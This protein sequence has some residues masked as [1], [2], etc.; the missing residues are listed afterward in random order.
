MTSE[1]DT[2]IARAV[3]AGKPGAPPSFKMA[4]Y[5]FSTFCG[6]RP[7]EPCSLTVAATHELLT[8]VLLYLMYSARI[9]VPERPTLC[10]SSYDLEEV[11]ELEGLDRASIDAIEQIVNPASGIHAALRQQGRHWAAHVLESPRSQLMVAFYILVTVTV[12][13]TPFSALAY[14]ISEYCA[15]SPGGDGGGAAARPWWSY[16]VG[17]LDSLVYFFLPLWT[18]VLLRLLQKRPWLHRIAGRSL[19]VGDTPWVSQSLEAFTSKLFALSYSV[20]GLSVSSG[21][22]LDHLVHR[23]THR[24]VR[25]ALLAVGRPDGRLNGLASAEATCSLSVSQASSI[26][27]WGVTLESFTLGH[28]PIKLGLSASAVFLPRVRKLFLCEHVLENSSGGQGRSSA[29]TWSKWPLGSAPAR[30]LC[31]LRAHLA[32]VGS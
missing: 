9:Y 3:R 17:F 6:L 22:P 1:W 8:Q 31:L 4:S 21:N 15:P 26:Q 25:G 32:V 23:H 14:G 30:P 24:V 5:V 12:G 10:D 27:N 16:V 19:L 29:A 2:C 13:W 7:A 20:A 11:R 28:N 18:T